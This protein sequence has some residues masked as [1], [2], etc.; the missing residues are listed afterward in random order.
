METGGALFGC[1]YTPELYKATMSLGKV[2]K[3]VK[4]EKK[5]KKQLI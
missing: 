5:K 3:I 2:A 1:D 4:N